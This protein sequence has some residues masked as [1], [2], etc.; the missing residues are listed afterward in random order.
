MSW[1]ELK[2]LIQGLPPDSNF[3]RAIH[4]ALADWTDE[5]EL[6]AGIFDGVQAGNWQ[7]GGG[8]GAEPS[9]YPR[10]K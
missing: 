4:G 5:K 3:G 9:R 1:R 8:K 10:P 7:R 6:L 2:V